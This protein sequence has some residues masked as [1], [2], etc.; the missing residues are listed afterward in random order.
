[1][2]ACE[3]AVKCFQDIISTLGG[4]NE[5]ERAH[6]LIQRLR[7]LPDLTCGEMNIVN[8]NLKLN[9]SGQ[10]KLRSLKVFQ[11]G[12][13]HKAMTVTSNHGFLRSARMQVN[14][15]QKNEQTRYKMYL[16]L[17][18]GTEIPAI[19]HEARALTERKEHTATPI[20]DD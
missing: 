7:V 11:F 10:V 6:R 14:N 5:T 16:K 9:I 20:L 3:T 12:I 4:P 13:C 18:Q 15:D 2:L 8:E 17:E 19:L 1:M